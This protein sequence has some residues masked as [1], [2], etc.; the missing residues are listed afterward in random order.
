MAKEAPEPARDGDTA[1]AAV[2]KALA[3]PIRRA[4]LRA[5]NRL[6]AARA[7]DLASELDMPAN[8]LSF[9]LRALADAGLI[10]EDPSLARD[11]RD[12]V[13]VPVEQ[14]INIGNP[15]RPVADE[16]L[17]G[18]AMRALIEE[19]HD[20]VR[21]TTRWA[22]E[23]MTGR[24]SVMHGVMSR[25]SARLTPAEFRDMHVKMLAVI[26]EARAAHDD[27]APDSS[28]YEIDIVGGDDTL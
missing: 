25:H 1:S 9:H 19:H 17:G 2:L 13:W 26:D 24:D 27:D 10:A 21:R 16:A 15:E 20:L 28:L 12:R 22:M 5:F 11:K 6:D 3:H 4:I 23:F 8:K 7:A 14:S 18:A